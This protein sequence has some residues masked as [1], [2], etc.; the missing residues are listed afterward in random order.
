M[1]PT[2]VKATSNTAAETVTPTIPA[3]ADDIDGLTAALAYAAAGLYVLPVLRGTKNP[4]SVVRSRWQDKSTRDP[5]VIAAHWSGTDH[6]IAVDL[7][8]SG[9]VV[10]DVDHPE[11]LPEWLTNVLA[12]AGARYQ[13]TRPDTP[14]RGHCVFRQPPGRVIGCGKGRLAGMGLDV[15]G[16]G[17]VII[18]Q[19]TRHPE[20]GEYRWITT[21]PIPVLPDVIAKLMDDSGH[22]E[23]AAT[24]PEVAAFIVEHTEETRPEIVH[25]HRR[26]FEEA[27]AAGQSRHTSMLAPLTFAMKEVAAGFYS[28]NT[29]TDILLPPF[30]VA[31]TRP[32]I[33]GETQLT[34]AQ[35][36]GAFY[37]MR[38]WCIGQANVADLDEVRAGVA[39]RMPPQRVGGTQAGFFGLDTPA[40]KCESHATDASGS[41][42][43]E[44]GSEE[45]HHRTQLGFARYFAKLYGGKLLYVHGIGWHYW[46][47]KRWAADEIGD[48]PR[49]VHAML[50]KIWSEAKG[51]KDLTKAI[52]R[53]ETSSSVESI[54]RL[55]STLK[56]FAVTVRDL[57]ADPYLFN[58]ADATLDLRTMAL[59]DHNPADR[60]T[61][62]A[63]GAARSNTLPGIVFHEF[64]ETVLPDSA[65]REY[66]QRLAGVSLLG[67]VIEHNLPILTG[68]GGNGKGTFYKG[69]SFSMGD[70]ADMVDPDIFMDRKGA[71]PTTE[72]DLRGLRLAVVSESS[73][74][75]ALDEARMKRLTGGD[76]INARKLYRD[77]VTFE[78]SHL[79]M[80]VTN[81]LPKV[82]GDDEAVWRRIRVVPFNVVITDPDGHME[83]KLQAEADAVLA[84]AIAGWSDYR[85]AGERLS[86]PS[87]VLIAT[88]KYRDNSDD[89]GRYLDDQDWV[90]R[91]PPLKST[92]KQLYEG[93][94]R[95]AAQEGADD[96]GL[97][98][99]GQVLDTKGFPVTQRTTKGRWRDGIAVNPMS[100]TSGDLGDL[101]QPVFWAQG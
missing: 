17:G 83:E 74:N 44:L 46:D 42:A 5:K 96:I 40:R 57:D 12:A 73:R 28:A 34:E 13:S 69:L 38:A 92:G 55:A 78:P 10:I 76:T 29:A 14:G 56:Q 84:W 1:A 48:A 65:I 43:I 11:M 80:L 31:K 18:V 89:V 27:V 94:Q 67:K 30:I 97:K 88:Q 8:R 33:N 7:G 101:S 62:V 79:P 3:L 63:R 86:E 91:Q 72:M 22:R 54:L 9:L 99:F 59:H 2:E 81:H 36:R 77:S 26:K 24:D 60:I 47:Q 37:N 15:K 66:L 95:W 19:P 25:G 68:S 53:C 100:P 35:A 93:Y 58:C 98:A 32:P 85:A 70:Y 52:I 50:D 45:Q 75:R 51:D 90:L 82:S 4:G 39:K 21:G 16:D 64:L 49:A 6:G 23:S 61:K 20:G 87:E 71:H 41:T